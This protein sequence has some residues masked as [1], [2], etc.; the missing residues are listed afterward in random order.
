MSNSPPDRQA[1]QEL[2]RKRLADAKVRLDFARHF[3]TEVK[4]DLQ[5]PDI[6]TP[7]G[8]YA[9]RRALRAETLALREYSRV[10]RIYQDL[11]V[12][13]VVPDEGAADPR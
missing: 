1:L 5:S 2:W 10:L 6:P 12:R 13:G 7:D 4:Q 11:A 8:S 3:V 9:Y